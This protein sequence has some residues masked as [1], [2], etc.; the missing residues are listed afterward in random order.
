MALLPDVLPAGVL[1]LQRWRPAQIDGVLAAVT[2]SFPELH[3]WMP[4]AATMPSAA[5]LTSVL[6][7][8]EASF[9]ADREWVYVLVERDSDEVVGSAGLHP[10]SGPGTIEIGYWV[11]TDRTGRGYA[12]EAARALA[13]AA[14]TWLDSVQRVEIRMDGANRASAA[15]PPKLGFR[16]LASERRDLLAP[17]HSGQGL[18]W[19]LDRPSSGQA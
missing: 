5:D 13:S 2:A 10:R 8:G 18:V 3:R 11:R 19:A 6:R 4:W 7:D 1:D 14:F 17:D 9:D 15:V 16:L 12:T